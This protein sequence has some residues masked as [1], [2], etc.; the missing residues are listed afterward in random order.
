MEMF[1]K[2]GDVKTR[3]GSYRMVTHRG[4]WTSLDVDPFG[5]KPDE[6]DAPPIGYALLAVRPFI[7]LKTKDG[8]YLAVK[9]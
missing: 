5:P 2:P 7:L 3:P 4:S 1:Y 9:T 6:T 8:K